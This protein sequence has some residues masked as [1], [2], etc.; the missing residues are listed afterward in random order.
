[1]KI[2]EAVLQNLQT[3]PF[4]KK[5]E[6]LDFVKFLHKKHVSEQPRRN[7]IGLFAELKLDITE[8]DIA[9]ARCELWGKFPRDVEV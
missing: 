3:L 2:E 9:E 1:M 8:D 7:P 5:Q 6:V 4:E